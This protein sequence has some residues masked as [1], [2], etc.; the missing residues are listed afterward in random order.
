[1]IASFLNDYI[2][3]NAKFDWNESPVQAMFLSA[4]KTWA[5]NQSLRH[6]V[7]FSYI[8]EVSVMSRKK[9]PGKDFMAKV[10]QQNFEKQYDGTFILSKGLC[11]C[12]YQ[13]KC[14]N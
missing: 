9:I 13:D 3:K 12:S 14:L 6:T 11:R 10:Y 7:R 4:G 2:D 8:T 1:M 5:L